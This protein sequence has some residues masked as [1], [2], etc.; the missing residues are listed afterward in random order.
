LQN[1][2]LTCGNYCREDA[3]GMREE[4]R[5]RKVDEVF[6]KEKEFRKEK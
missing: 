6:K 1:D 5:K 2:K 3:E 4:W